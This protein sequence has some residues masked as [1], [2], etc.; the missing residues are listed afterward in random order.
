MGEKFKPYKDY[1]QKMV[2]SRAK[3]IQITSIQIRG[4]LLYFKMYFYN[5]LLTIEFIH[6]LKDKFQ[7]WNGSDTFVIVVELLFLHP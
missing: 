7:W 4:V 2:T 3:P 1:S 5:Y 6:L